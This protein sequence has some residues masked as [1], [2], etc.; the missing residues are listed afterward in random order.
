MDSYVIYFKP[1]YLF[2]YFNN[3]S[4][5]LHQWVVEKMKEGLHIFLQQAT[6]LAGLMWEK[7]TSNRNFSFF[8]LS[9][10]LY[11]L[12]NIVVFQAFLISKFYFIR[13]N[14]FTII[15]CEIF[16]YIIIIFISNILT[17]SA[18]LATNKKLSKFS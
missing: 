18:N 16:L 14:N 8:K 10:I 7:I 9:F 3:P 12:L 1:A 6:N 5:T 13:H 15:R 2:S 4:H 11:F 17:V